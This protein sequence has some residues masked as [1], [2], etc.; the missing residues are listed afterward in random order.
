MKCSTQYHQSGNNPKQPPLKITKTSI[1]QSFWSFQI[2]AIGIPNTRRML[3]SLQE[4]VTSKWKK[5]TFVITIERCHIHNIL[6]SKY[7]SFWEYHCLKQFYHLDPHL[8]SRCSCIQKT[9]AGLLLVLIA[10]SSGV[11]NM[12]KWIHHF[13]KRHFYLLSEDDQC[14]CFFFCLLVPWRHGD[15]IFNTSLNVYFIGFK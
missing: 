15:V 5:D 8:I 3:H 12:S 1:L 13:I 14:G 7:L 9:L 10:M 11:W 4:I 2:Y 6:V